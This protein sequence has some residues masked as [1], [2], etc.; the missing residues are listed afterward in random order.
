M[1]TSK[2]FGKLRRPKR[3]R[4]QLYLLNDD[5]NSFQYVIRVLTSVLPLCNSLRAEQI[6]RLVDTSGECEIYSGFPPE[7]YLLYANLQKLGLTAQIR[8]YNNKNKKL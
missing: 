3:K 6:A 8:Q 5:K 4:M 2:S 7:I 1:E